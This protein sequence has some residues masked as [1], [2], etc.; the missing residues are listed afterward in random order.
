MI[1]VKKIIAAILIMIGSL[2]TLS[3]LLTQ[4]TSD[5]PASNE[6]AFLF[7]YYLAT[8][9]FVAIGVLLIFWGFRIIRNIRRK[10]IKK[11]LI[12]SLPD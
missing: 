11:N 3:E 9:V 1:V 10:K 12:D 2:V 8:V 4:I 7:G 5:G 6:P